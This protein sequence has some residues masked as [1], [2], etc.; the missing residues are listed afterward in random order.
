MY[1]D[2]HCHLTFPDFHPDRAMVIGN[3]KKAGVKKFIVPGVDP[4]SSK[5]AVELA[6]KHPGVV[7]ASL[8]FHPYEAQRSQGIG[9]LESLLRQWN[10]ETMKQ[11]HIVAI[12]ECGLDYHQYKGEKAA[13]KK[14]AQMILFEE[15]LRL[16]LRFNLPLIIHCRDAWEDLFPV[17]DGLPDMPRGVLHCFSGGLQE[18]RMARERNL[19]IGIDGNVTYAKQMETIVPHIPLE[20][21]LLETDSPYLTPLPHRGTRNEPKY[22][23]LV[24]KK[25]ADL[26]KKPVKEIEVTTARNAHSLFQLSS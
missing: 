7:F 1:I 15:H 22:L 10:N 19:C 17:L 21:L 8:G 3:A 6:K 18:L 9:V 25:I 2:T 16:A 5:Q 11:F 14:T 12:G 26:M 13:G 23:P 4:L 24:A 20:S